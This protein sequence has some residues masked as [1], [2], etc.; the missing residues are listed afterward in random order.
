MSCIQTQILAAS[1]AATM[2][3]C[4]WVTTVDCKRCETGK[5]YK[6][7]HLKVQWPQWFLTFPCRKDFLLMIKLPI[8]AFDGFKSSSYRLL[9]S[10]VEPTPLFRG[11]SDDS[12]SECYPSLQEQWKGNRMVKGWL[13]SGIKPMQN[14]LTSIL[15]VLSIAF[16][17]IDQ[18]VVLI[19][20]KLTRN[21]YL[22]FSCGEAKIH[23]DFKVQDAKVLSNAVM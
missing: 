20:Y 19:H 7:N 5:F 3:P 1:L 2:D 17:S 23:C 12:G 14:F 10:P 9:D 6:Q 18:R 4:P 21:D 16:D 15:L 11:D 13:I 8:L 22:L